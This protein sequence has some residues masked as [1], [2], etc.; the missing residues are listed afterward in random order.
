[1]KHFQ[2]RTSGTCSRMI[3]FD[4]DDD[5]RLHN[6]S[7]LGGCNGN[8]K[9]IGL[10]V[11]GADALTVAQKLAGN[12]CGNKPTSCPDQLSRAIRQAVDQQ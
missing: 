8:T 10:L 5:G 4:L 12:T 1:M 7:F 2:Y 9:G 11:E 6:V 3:D